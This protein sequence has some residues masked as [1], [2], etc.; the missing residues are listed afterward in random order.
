MTPCE[1]VCIKDEN[2]N[3][4]EGEDRRPSKKRKSWG[5]E[6]PVPKTNLPPR[7]AHP[8]PVPSSP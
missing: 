2:E 1:S 8:Y 7:Y 6:L 4:E 3:D 5:Q